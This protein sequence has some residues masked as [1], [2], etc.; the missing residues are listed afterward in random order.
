MKIPF[1]T[2][3]KERKD[4]FDTRALAATIGFRPRKTEYYRL[5]F[6]DPALRSERDVNRIAT[7]D[8]L[9]FLGDSILGM[10][11]SRHL[12]ETHP[13]WPVGQLSALKAHIVSRSVSNKIASELDL[14]RFFPKHP[15]T[16][17]SKDALGNALEA[18]I[19]AIFLDKGFP[20]VERFILEKFLPLYYREK[21]EN[22]TFGINY[23]GEL[24]AWADRHGM[25]IVYAT[26]ASGRGYNGGFLSE[27]YIN[28]RK[29]G[30]GHGST[31]KKGEQEAA[32]QALQ[33]IERGNSSAAVPLFSSEIVPPT[34]TI[35]SPL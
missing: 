15:E 23:K 29:M 2:R 30:I 35:N 32:Q 31:K 14:G 10:F 22:T 13:N 25:H 28:Q 24:Q 12:Y 18:L 11:V 7:N 1:L 8:R 34:H 16:S 4:A 27:V 6:I 26:V 17:Y 33:E 5:A 21:L 9:E 19:A 3:R 20:T